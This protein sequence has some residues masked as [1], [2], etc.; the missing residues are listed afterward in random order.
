MPGVVPHYKAFRRKL[1]RDKAH[2]APLQ[3]LG[4]IEDLLT[5]EFASSILVN[6]KWKTLPLLNVGMSGDKRRIDVALISGDISERVNKNALRIW[7]FVE[8]KYL[9]NKHRIGEANAQDELEPTFRS[10]HTQLKRLNVSNFAG[11]PVRLRAGIGD[12][13][14]LVFASYVHR[15]SATN[16]PDAFVK[17]IQ[18]A[19]RNHGFQT[20]NFKS[21]KLYPIYSDVPVQ[22]LGATYKVS[23]FSGL[24]RLAGEACCE[25]DTE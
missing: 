17:R 7:A 13:Y 14:G 21:P 3:L 5:K 23:L 4:R 6:S 20:H 1:L 16:T 9:R 12:T 10:L 8:L 25:C 24:W 18:E 22:I 2:I 15:A 19:A 11:Y